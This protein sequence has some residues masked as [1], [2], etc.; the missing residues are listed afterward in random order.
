VGI[1]GGGQLARM[2]VEAAE[3]AGVRCRVLAKPSDQSAEHVGADVDL[4][5]QIDSAAVAAFAEGLDV[6]TFDYEPVDFA[7]YE[8]LEASGF[9]VRPSVAALRFSDKAYQRQAFAEAGLPVPPFACVTTPE[10]C[11]AFAEDH[12]W[13]VVLKAPRGG[14]DGRGVVV[15]GDP[16][17]AAAVLDGQ[18][19]WV[20]EAHLELDAEVAALVATWPDGRSVSFP[21]FDT[22]QSDG[23]CV[24]VRVPSALP[25][26]LQSEA[27]ELGR[28]V[29]R[30][31]GAVGMLAVELFVVGG[32]VLVNEIAPRPHN[33][34]HLT[35]EACRASQFELHLRAVA[36]LPPTQPALVAPA[37]VMANVV[38]DS[39]GPAGFPEVTLGDGVFVHD[40][41][42]TRRPNR[43]VGHVTALGPDVETAA[44]DA[45]AGAQRV[46]AACLAADVGGST[47]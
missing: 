22:L 17:A 24:E 44:R 15:V 40:Y 4:V 5:E 2:M 11:E 16:A 14:Y 35:I 29:A 12:G 39:D 25:E 38:A 23:I 47:P 34:G 18:R 30:V 27:L 28:R 32:R 10:Q 31:V 21:L 1:I 9:A 42:K 33:S 36:G 7:P 3:A 13:P 26:A 46:E 41:G 8:Q 19:L 6:L 20:A 45:H 37:A 43:K